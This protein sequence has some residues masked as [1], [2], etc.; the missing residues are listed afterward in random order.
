MKTD[1]QV[2]GE[3][4][5][6]IAVT[7]NIVVAK[8]Q[9]LDLINEDWNCAEGHLAWARVLLAEKKFADAAAAFQTTVTLRPNDANLR[10]E[11]AASLI[12]AAQ[13]AQLLQLTDW[14]AARDSILR[15][16]EIDPS[17]PMGQR[18]LQYVEDKRELVL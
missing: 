3:A 1:R 13:A 6:A 7:G 8:E 9:V 2:R 5:A 14:S 4:A 12:E 17:N 10:F 15:G 11:Y 18:L 16:L